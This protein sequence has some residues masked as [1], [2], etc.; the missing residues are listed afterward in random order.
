MKDK[1]VKT[2]LTKFQQNLWKVLWNTQKIQFA[3]LCK[4]RFIMNQYG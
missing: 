1:L 4:V 2:A 3:A